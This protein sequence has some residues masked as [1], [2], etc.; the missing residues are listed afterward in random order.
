MSDTLETLQNSLAS[1]YTVDRPLGRGGMATVYLAHDIKYERAVA[2]KVL[3][4]ELS[5]SIGAE[6]FEREIR[7]AA[8]LQHPNILGL[9]E[10]GEAEGLLY[11]VMPF[12]DGES[13]RDR[14][15]RDGQLPIEDAVQYVLEVADALGYAHHQGI[16]HRD[17]KPENVLISNNHAL[18]ADFGIARAASEGG[19]PKLTQTGMAIGTPVYM[20]PEQAAG[21]KVGPP[22]DIYSMGCLLY[23][24]LA[25]EPP[26]MG[27][28]AVAIMARHALETVP[29]IRI[30]R[31]AVPPEVE[32][33]IFAAMAKTPADRPQTAAQFAEILGV[34]IGATASRR[35]FMRHTATRRIPTP[36]G[37]AYPSAAPAPPPPPP[38]VPFWRR[39]VLVGIAALLLAGAGVVAWRLTKGAPL[40]PTTDASLRRVAVLYFDDRSPDHSLQPLA[41][42]LTEALIKALSDVR[43]L[44][45]VS[46]NG[47][48]PFRGTDVSKDSIARALNVGTVVEG[49]VER[50]GKDGVRVTTRLR[51]ASGG[52]LGLHTNMVV[53]QDRLYAAADS[54]A[55]EVAR[56]LQQLLGQEVQLREGQSGTSNMTAWTLLRRAEN[57]RNDADNAET[58]DP[59]RAITLLAQ[60]DSLL[61]QAEAADPSWIEPI[62]L[63]GEVAYKLVPLISDAAERIKTV[64]Q[65]LMQARRA[66]ALDGANAKALALR[67]ELQII[68]WQLGRTTDPAARSALL[69][70]AKRDLEQATQQDP[71]LASAYALLSGIDYE[72]VPADVFA[73][74]TH[75]RSAYEADA[76]LA[77]SDDILDRLFWASYDT[78]NFNEATKWCTE[79]LRRFPKDVRFTKCRLWLMLSSE[80][81]PDIGRAWQLAAQVDSIAPATGRKYDVSQARVIVA[82][83]IGRASAKAATPAAKAAL[84]DSANRVLLAA[85]A[86]RTVDPDQEL[87]GYEAVVRA[88]MGD[89]DGAIEL[90]KRYIA[91]NPG[92]SFEVGGNIHWWWRE[93]RS[94]NPKFQALLDSRKKQHP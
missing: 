64:D 67:G 72:E 30:V 12:I 31:S 7:L 94:S 11:Y 48:A 6:R 4:P 55:L 58:Q 54:V 75:A 13:L 49:L 89:Q 38:P 40:K 57:L 8:K 20:A 80:S 83:V 29:S 10:S 51:D 47:V 52:D 25:G 41:D 35:A 86:D 19:G 34:P 33:A 2:I 23:E 24:L 9:Y 61:Q 46:R 18:V 26:F 56:K 36:P 87:P 43:I 70:S 62:I 3:H 66:L 65:G 21:E 84:K 32:E 28:S 69:Q 79:G 45:V 5:A 42:G 14:L 92:H 44:A 90:L 88:L 59:A 39:P 78:E 16:V 17:I 27:K 85:R 76:Y 91:Q 1:R 63:R 15:E 53:K 71:S 77:N 60:S 74:L 81:Q 93:L 22:A 37:E 73:A 68:S 50:S 82:G